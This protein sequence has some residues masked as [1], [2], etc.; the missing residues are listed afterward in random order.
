MH[1]STSRKDLRRMLKE[2]EIKPVEH[3][4]SWIKARFLLPRLFSGKPGLM[5]CWWVVDAVADERK[6]EKPTERSIVLRWP[7]KNSIIPRLHLW[8]S[9]FFPSDAASQYR[10]VTI[11]LLPTGLRSWFNHSSVQKG[12]T[13]SSLALSADFG[14]NIKFPCNDLSVFNSP[15]FFQKLVIKSK[16]CLNH[17]YTAA[18]TV[19]MILL[20][21][22]K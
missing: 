10:T 6:M 12:I 13:L 4:N 15:L 1:E 22:D 7:V 14:F 21:T 17:L 2:R 9:P 11:S 5:D 8:L 19:Y 18:R 16:T 3:G 20:S